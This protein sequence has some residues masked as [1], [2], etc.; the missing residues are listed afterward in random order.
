MRY[1]LSVTLTRS[2]KCGHALVIGITSIESAAGITPIHE[3]TARAYAGEIPESPVVDGIFSEW[4]DPFSDQPFDSEDASVD[5]RSHGSAETDEFTMFY[6]SVRGK[7]LQ[8][9]TIHTRS[10][11]TLPSSASRND[12]YRSPSF[13]STIP[14]LPVKSGEDVFYLFLDT[15]RSSGYTSYSGFL[16]DHLVEVKGRAGIIT[17]ATLLS[18]NGTSTGSWSWMPQ[19]EI[20][21]ALFGAEIELS[22][23]LTGIDRYHVHLISWEGDQDWTDPDHLPDPLRWFRG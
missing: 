3:E 15:D 2:V 1:T 19:D 6:T 18:F 23:P 22:I 7:M 20:D 14:P 5:I 21:T 9:R 4:D 17:S 16:A 8:G 11:L 10:I 13:T 12:A